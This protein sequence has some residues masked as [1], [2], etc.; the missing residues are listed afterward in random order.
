MYEDL[1][2]DS[3]QEQTI[4]DF[5]KTGPIANSYTLVYWIKGEEPN[6]WFKA[7]L[8]NK[9]SKLIMCGVLGNSLDIIKTSMI[10]LLTESA[11]YD[12]DDDD[13]TDLSNIDIDDDYLEGEYDE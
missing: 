6:T 11:D 4:E 9:S 13:L 2:L 5:N 3:I 7:D 1:T 8:Y 12:D 10:E